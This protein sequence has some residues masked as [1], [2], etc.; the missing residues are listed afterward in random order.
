YHLVNNAN[1]FDAFL[2]QLRKQERVAFDLETTGLE[3]LRSEVVGYSFCWRPAE[4][5]YLAVRGPAG[6]PTLDPDETLA[7][8]RPMFEDA[9]AAWRLCEL[10][11]PKLKEQKLDG[12]YRDL[13]IP[14]IG[15]LAELEC[16]GIRLDLPLLERLSQEMTAQ[17]AMIEKEIHDLAGKA[18]NIAS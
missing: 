4:A 1:D 11:E 12:L 2:K 16:N 17:L 9:A 15:V 14:L 13:E 10:L 3:P 6:E 5:W 8:L 18:F 7:K